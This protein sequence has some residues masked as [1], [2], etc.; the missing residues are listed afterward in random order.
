MTVQIISSTNITKPRSFASCRD[1][2]ASI[3]SCVH[4][5]YISVYVLIIGKE[6]LNTSTMEN[7]RI[8]VGGKW[9]SVMVI[10][11]LLYTG[12]RG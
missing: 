1:H 11:W 5:I 3:I 10:L 6:I 9:W 2:H 7:K 12:R 8:Q 4:C